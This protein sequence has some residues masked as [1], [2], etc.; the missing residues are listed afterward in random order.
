[1]RLGNSDIDIV[2]CSSV[3]FDESELGPLKCCKVVSE[4]R[5]RDIINQAVTAGK[6]HLVGDS[7]D[8]ILIDLPSMGEI[9]D[10]GV[11]A[12]QNMVQEN[13]DPKS[14]SC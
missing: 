4:L 13:V 7:A 12:Q 9:V 8:Q 5:Q 11:A 1:M 2:V 10:A 14:K 3:V 6:E